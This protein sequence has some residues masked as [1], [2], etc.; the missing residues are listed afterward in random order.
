MEATAAAIVH[1]AKKRPSG[2]KCPCAHFAFFYLY[3]LNASNKIA[4]N[5][6]STRG[7]QQH[8]VHSEHG[9]ESAVNTVKDA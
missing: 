8:G 4:P 9:C 6:D 1:L 5:Y 3:L 7:C 2:E